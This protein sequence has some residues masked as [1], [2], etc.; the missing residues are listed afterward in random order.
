MLL[1]LALVGPLSTELPLSIPDDQWRRI[2]DRVDQ[3]LEKKLEA[4][5]RQNDL[6]KRLIEKKKLGVGV[7]DLSDPLNPR[8]AR[9]NGRTM[10]YAA[11]LPKIAILLAAYACFE[12]G[13]LQETPEIRKDLGLMIRKSDN[14]AATR[15]ID[16]IGFDKIQAVLMDSRYQLYDK[17]RGGGLWVGKRYAK[18]GDRHP[19]PVLGLS[20][21]ATVTQVCRFYYMLAYGRIINPE[22]S[23]QIL[24]HLSK[25]GIRH[26]FVSVLEQ[27][28]PLASLFR[29]SGTWKT[30]HSDSVLVWG[31]VWR[32]YVLVAMVESEEG[33]QILKDLV[34][35]VEEI[36]NPP[37][38]SVARA[39]DVPPLPQTGTKPQD[40]P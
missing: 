10:M 39:A 27:R 22:R 29:K 21:A 28:A 19:D 35:L 15:M 16:C 18:T 38:D 32:R 6:R 14:P 11:S 8:F 5:L 37:A 2:Y 9:V 24:A 3:A 1:S 25:P 13:T 7:V 31:P 40:L 4:A 20:H 33:E 26:K 17:E 34:P 30:W 12:D 23:R 36:L